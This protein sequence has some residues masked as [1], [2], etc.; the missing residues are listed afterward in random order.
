MRLPFS[1]HRVLPDA[2]NGVYLFTEVSSP[3]VYLDMVA[4]PQ[5][6]APPITFSELV[7][8]ISLLDANP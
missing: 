2:P 3:I 4:I 6:L 7:P 5:L 1:S 8:A